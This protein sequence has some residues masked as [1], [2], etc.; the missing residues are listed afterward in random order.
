LPTN[1]P[2]SR[3]TN[4][5]PTGL[6]GFRPQTRTARSARVSP[7]P[8]SFANIKQGFSE[9]RWQDAKGWAR[10][11]LAHTSNRKYRP[12]EKQKPDQGQQA[13]RLSVLP[14]EDGTLSHRAIPRVDDPPPRRHLL[15]VSVQHPDSGAPLRGLP[16]MEGPTEDSL[17]DRPRGDPQAPRLHPGPGLYQHRGAAR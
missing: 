15:V 10:K 17:G 9:R 16:P 12:S 2:S 1:G 11:K 13:P 8:R 3:Q 4:R 6:N 14:A 5:M 7:L